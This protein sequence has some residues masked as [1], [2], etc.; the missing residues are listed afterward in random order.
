MVFCAILP[1]GSEG[2][3][4]GASGRGRREEDLGIAKGGGAKRNR[5]LRRP[6]RASREKFA[7]RQDERKSENVCALLPWM[8]LMQDWASARMRHQIRT[9][10]W[11]GTLCSHMTLWLASMRRSGLCSCAPATGSRNF[12]A[13]SLIKVRLGVLLVI[14]ST[15]GASCSHNASK[16]TKLAKARHL[17][18]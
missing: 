17:Q 4:L 5:G 10:I 16:S 7:L 6:Y 14:R 11:R 13:T 3:G 8:T 15:S 18:P 12:M 9:E 1:W 2:N